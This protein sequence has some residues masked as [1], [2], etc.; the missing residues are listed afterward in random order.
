MVDKLKKEFIPI[1]YEFDLFKKMQGLKKAGK[2]VQE[3]TKEHYWVLI[4]VGH[5]EANK[6]KVF[7]YLNVLR[8]S[9]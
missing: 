8:P 6:E 4:G 1:D 2:F 5:V 3:Y 7:H 9:I